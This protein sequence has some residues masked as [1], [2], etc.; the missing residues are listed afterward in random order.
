VYDDE[1]DE[2]DETVVDVTA[3]GQ[4]DRALT[5]TFAPFQDTTMGDY[6]RKHPSNRDISHLGL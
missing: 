2:G 5:F 3:K 6:R 4:K 1:K